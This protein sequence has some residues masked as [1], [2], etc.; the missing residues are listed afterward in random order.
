MDEKRAAADRRLIAH[1]LVL[2]SLS[3][4]TQTLIQPF[5]TMFSSLVVLSV[6]VAGALASPVARASGNFRLQAHVTRNDLSPSVDGLFVRL[7]NSKS[8]AILDSAPTAVGDVFFQTGSGSATTIETNAPTGSSEHGMVITPGGTA[9]VPSENI[10][11]LLPNNAGTSGVSIDASGKLAFQNGA[12][13]ACPP[14]TIGAAGSEVVLSFKK[15][16]QRSIAGCADVDIVS[17]AA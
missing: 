5:F 12:F 11:T 10:I 17:V 2:Y 13:M 3:Y 7:D 9:T 1:L 16:G 4:S 6:A 14:A 15:A 8:I